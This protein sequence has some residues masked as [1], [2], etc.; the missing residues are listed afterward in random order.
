MQQW[1]RSGTTPEIDVEVLV[2]G[3]WI[4]SRVHGSR[5]GE[6]GQQTLVSW[7]T[8]RGGELVRHEAWMQHTHLRAIHEAD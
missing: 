6:T 1:D 4:R 2:E 8:A 3:A 5:R 7:A